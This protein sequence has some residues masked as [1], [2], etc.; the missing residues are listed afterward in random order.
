MRTCT[1]PGCQ[2]KHLAKGFC[3]RHLKRF[4]TYGDPMFAQKP[5]KR[6]GEFVI[7]RTGY[8]R[9]N[10]NRHVHRIA[11]EQMLGRPL[12]GNEVVHHIDGDKTNN[13][14]SNLMVFASHAEHAAH[15]AAM[16]RQQQIN[17]KEQQA[18]EPTP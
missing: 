15:H 3:N 6:D 5:K 17:H 4:K 13:H 1:V 16:R 14:P 8:M 18:W 2:D 12:R 9:I 10:G 7:D 11:A